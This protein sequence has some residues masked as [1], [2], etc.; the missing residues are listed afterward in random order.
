MKFQKTLF[1][2]NN[3]LYF[4]KEEPLVKNF[5][6]LYETLEDLYSKL[7][8]NYQIGIGSSFKELMKELSN[9]QRAVGLS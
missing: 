7:P 4:Y 8:E 3:K 5:K 2:L 6:Q 1:D 9:K